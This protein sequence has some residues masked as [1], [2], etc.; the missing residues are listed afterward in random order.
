MYQ[1]RMTIS[2]HF[3]LCLLFLGDLINALGL[4]YKLSCKTFKI[5]FAAL[6]SALNAGLI[7][8]S[9]SLTL[10]LLKAAKLNKHQMELMILSFKHDPHPLCPIMVNVTSQLSRLKAWESYLIPLHCPSVALSD[11]T[12]LTFSISLQ[13]SSMSLIILW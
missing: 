2:L 9:A 13:F 12:D 6:N 1:R 10:P 8:P 4:N 5:Y 7:C 3:V 11:P